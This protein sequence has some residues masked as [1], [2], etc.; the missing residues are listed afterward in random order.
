MSTAC[1]SSTGERR[2]LLPNAG[3]N[4]TRDVA[5]AMA[6]RLAHTWGKARTERPTE[7]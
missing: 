4:R 6:P 5:A 2:R 7:K 3:C 1:A